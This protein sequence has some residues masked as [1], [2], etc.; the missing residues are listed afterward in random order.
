MMVNTLRQHFLYVDWKQ[1]MEITDV[2]KMKNRYK[3]MIAIAITTISL[4]ASD[5]YYLSYQDKEL[6]KSHWV[7]NCTSDEPDRIVPAIGL[8]N[9]THSFDLRTCTWHPTE[10]GTPGFLE[11]LYISF[12][13]PAFLDIANSLETKYVYASCIATIPPQPCF[14]SF[15]VSAEGPL[16]EHTIME[17]YARNIELNYP[18][19]QMSDR[20]WVTEDDNAPLQLPAIICTE[21]VIDGTKQYRMA[22]W[23]D[24]H[25][26]S[27][28]ENFRD[29]SLCDKWLA[30]ID[31]GVKI[32][33]SKPNY[34]SNGIGIVQVTDN[35]MNQNSKTTESFGI[36]VKSDVD[37]AGIELTVT[38][39]HID[40]GIFEGTVFFT[41]NGKSEGAQLLVED[42]VHAEHKLS[43]GS[44]R[45]IN[46]FGPQHGE[47]VTDAHIDFRN[48]DGEII[49]KGYTSE[50]GFLEYPECGPIDQFVINVL[51]IV[52]P[53]AGIIIVVISVWRKRR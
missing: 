5:Q 28:F 4:L 41:P 37:R 23:S 8:F 17:N 53:I 15:M 52:L 24:S 11:S 45:I 32:S 39:T 13:E 31:D 43:V 20:N 38:E 22:K 9:H 44:A 6:K 34:A 42:T 12:M 19:W 21:F 33:W 2:K 25:T 7:Q 1:V 10:Y 35:D 47:L 29:D 30:P 26:I 50:G 40:S 36:R 3:I 49:C 46:E 48:V 27:S 18:D 14:D 16:T 51:V